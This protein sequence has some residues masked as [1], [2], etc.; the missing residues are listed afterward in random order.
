VW[1]CFQRKAIASSQHLAKLRKASQPLRA[2]PMTI[3]F[4][5]TSLPVF[6]R[7]KVMAAICAMLTCLLGGAAPAAPGQLDPTFGVGGRVRLQDLIVITYGASSRTQAGATL[8]DGRIVMA[9]TCPTVASSSALCIWRFMPDGSADPSFGVSG[10]T[11]DVP[12]G[13]VIGLHLEHDGAMQL[14]TRCAV[15]EVCVHRFLANGTP[16]TTFG[17]GGIARAAFSAYNASSLNMSSLRTDNGSLFIGATCS[18]VASPATAC[19][20]KLTADGVR[21]IS[22]AN[23]GQL[24]LAK[25][26]SDVVETL[27]LFSDGTLVA[28]GICWSG[29]AYNFCHARF[30]SLGQQ[31]AGSNG[32]QSLAIGA[33]VFALSHIFPLVQGGSLFVGTCYSQFGQRFCVMKVTDAFV[34]DATYGGLGVAYVSMGDDDA[35]LAT[36]KLTA[37]VG[38]VM[39]G[40]CGILMGNAVAPRFCSAAIDAK[41]SLLSSFATNGKSIVDVGPG[42]DVPAVSILYGTGK[43]LVGGDCT[44]PGSASN[45]CMIRL[46]GGPYNPQTCALNADA[47]QTVDPATDAL[48]LT[49]YLLGFRGPALSNGAVGPNPTRTG[50]ALEDYLGTLN[51]DVDGDGAAFAMT[52]GLLM[53][54]AM[55]GLTGTALTQGA[56]NVAHPNVRN[57]QQILTWI[58]D[59]HGVACLP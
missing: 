24:D 58:E 53:L 17:S 47:N 3:N 38:L 49:R 1:L 20:L 34:V 46:K 29:I 45:L 25:G 22:F 21:D 27:A 35:V 15:A 6:C 18:Y 42:G 54:R 9:G 40:R 26:P 39:T 12:V 52:D 13:V 30:T 56:T 11:T 43:V 50:Q 41:G 23:G 55:L 10:R 32:V 33:D 14:V 31:L 7:Q 5:C 36:A 16:Q 59:T 51:L 4:A 2:A 48:L 44:G 19:V 37:G 57:A 28:G 8:D